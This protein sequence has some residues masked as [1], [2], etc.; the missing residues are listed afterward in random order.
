MA[1]LKEV[2]N[3]KIKN[4]LM[5]EFSYK[6]IHQVPKLTKIVVNSCSRDCLVNSKVGAKINEE[7]SLITGQKAMPSKAKKSVAGFKLREGQIL[8][9]NVTLRGSTMYEFLDRLVNITLPRVRDFRG[10]SSKSFDK[11]GNYTLGIKEQI[12]FPEIDYDKIDKV[13]G[14]NITFVTTANSKNES[15][16]LLGQLGLPFEK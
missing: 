5:D 9:A 4:S 8:G 1:R 10:I 13:R 7:L 11:S 12:I 16:S 15:Q 2:Y 6:N 14:L 3:S